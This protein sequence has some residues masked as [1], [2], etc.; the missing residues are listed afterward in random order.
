MAMI[1]RYENVDFVFNGGDMANNRRAVVGIRCG[2]LP[3]T[4]NRSSRTTKLSA[5]KKWTREIACQSV[6][7]AQFDVYGILRSQGIVLYDNVLIRNVLCTVAHHDNLHYSKDIV[8]VIFS[9]RCQH[10]LCCVQED[11]SCV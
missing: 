7:F 3:G 1:D 5:T 8:R 10:S 4:M 11:H 6:V 9:H 2:I